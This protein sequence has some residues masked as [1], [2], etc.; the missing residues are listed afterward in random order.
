MAIYGDYVVTQS[1]W[2]IGPADVVINWIVPTV[3]VI[4]FWRNKQATLGK[5]APIVGGQKCLN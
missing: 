4:V 2:I 5:M 1:K 3:A